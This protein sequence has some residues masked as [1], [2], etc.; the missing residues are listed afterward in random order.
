MEKHIFI[1]RICWSSDGTASNLSHSELPELHGIV[2]ASA[3]EREWT[4][5]VFLRVTCGRAIGFYVGHVCKCSTIGLNRYLFDS[6]RSVGRRILQGVIFFLVLIHTRL[7][8]TGKRGVR[9]KLG[10]DDVIR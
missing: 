1:N 5:T 8:L 9:Q 7:P 10:T 2:C 3:N 4:L 6:F